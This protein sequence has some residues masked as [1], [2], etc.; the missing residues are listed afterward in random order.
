MRGAPRTSFL[1]PVYDCAATLSAAIDSALAQ[2][3]PDLEV[4]VVDDGSRDGSG[5]VARRVADR[6]PRVRVLAIPHGGIVAALNAGLAACRGELIA[7]LDADDEAAPE[8]LALQI[9]MLEASPELGVVDGQVTLF[10]DEG[11]VPGGMARYAE[12]INGVLTPDDFDRELLVESP[13]LHPAATFRR[14]AVLALG[15]YRDGP[16]PE[17]YDLWL[18]MHAAGWR[19]A[20]VPRVLLRMR[21]RPER[22]TRTHPRYSRAAFRTAR[23]MWLAQTALSQPRPVALWG[24]GKEGKR[25]LRW[26]VERGCDVVGVVEVDPRKIGQRLRGAPVVPPEALS[27]LPAD[28]ALVAV[29]ARG[30]RAQI[31]AAMKD[32]RPGWVE[33]RDWWAVC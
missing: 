8:R 6:D 1:L 31:R 21:D 12:W 14:S 26:L 29:G 2:T 13:I 32:L 7:R 3:D 9:P 30:A 4:V 23:Q 33:G 17:D 27:A 24:A 20:K 25:W 22:L 18:R 10:R 5:E 15:G 28:L 11:E 16:F 19:L